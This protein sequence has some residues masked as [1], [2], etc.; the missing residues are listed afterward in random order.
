MFFPGRAYIRG[1]VYS[2]VK[3]GNKFEGP[4]YG[5]EYIRGKYIRG[6]GLTGFYGSYVFMD[7]SVR[8]RNL[9]HLLNICLHQILLAFY[10]LQ[11]SPFVPH[12]SF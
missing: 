11:P 1:W 9:V 4:I 6:G 2:G 3:I 8:L 10:L 12:L 5:G 7:K